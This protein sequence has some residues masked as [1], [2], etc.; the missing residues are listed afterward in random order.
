MVSPEW[1]NKIGEIGIDDPARGMY[2]SPIYSD[3]KTVRILNWWNEIIVKGE[4]K[5]PT[6]TPVREQIP[7]R[8]LT[9]LEKFSA[10]YTKI[11][12]RSGGKGHGTV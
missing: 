3:G 1:G 6:R 2:V 7:R 12:F 5:I 8:P 9:W 10:W 4:F 11:C